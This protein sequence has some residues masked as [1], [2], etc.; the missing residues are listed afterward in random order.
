MI[1]QGADCWKGIVGSTVC[2]HKMTRRGCECE[3]VGLG[4]R[5]RNEFR[6]SWYEKL[7][8]RVTGRQNEE[9]LSLLLRT[10]ASPKKFI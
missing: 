1:P 2:C 4:V 8:S 7:M 6:V 3:E 9:N 10:V 5:P